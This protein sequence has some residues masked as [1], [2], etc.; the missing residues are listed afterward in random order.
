MSTT[1][2]WRAAA[3][4]L[5][6]AVAAHG[7]TYHVNNKAG[8]DA[9]DGRTAQAAFATIAKAT[10]TARTSDSIVLAN[11]G[12]PYR[13]PIVLRGLGGTVRKPFV[14]EGNGAVITGLKAIAAKDWQ[15]TPKGTLFFAV[16]RKPYGFP[17]LVHEGARLPAARNAESI[18]PGQF[19]WGDKGI[20]FRPAAG[21]RLA[22]YA[23]EATL[24]VSGLE[25]SGA[26]YVTCRNLASEYHS[27]DGFNVHGDC[28]GIVCENIVGRHNGDD[29]FSVHET[30]G[31]VVRNGHFHHNRWGIQDV[32]ASR[33]VFNGVT[34]EHNE[35]NGADF[36]G[37]YHSLVDCVVRDNGRAQIN[38]HGAAPKH[39][40][41]SERNPLCK[42]ILYLSNVVATG[43]SAGLAVSGGASAVAE[44]C[45]FAGSEAGVQVRKDSTL[46]L[47]TSIVAATKLEL[48][49]MGG[50]CFRD[51]NLYHP[52]RF[53]WM[54]K[55][56]PPAQWDA[57][58]AAAS[59][60][61]H[62]LLADPKLD[63]GF[64]PAAGSP[65]AKHRPRIGPS[66]PQ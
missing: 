16:T 11:T 30:I 14:I 66:A 37:G 57:F 1:G 44:H 35:I 38:V 19:F 46:H 31:A 29:G 10:A 33:S 55:V 59:H 20:H 42:G 3:V 54:G 7:A 18:E 27:N 50:T 5:A 8:D 60:D 63:A 58:R 32:N 13:E 15:P 61:E 56:Y 48:D 45:V 39:L 25:V 23:L 65:A 62:S 4:L 28:R 34:C 51:H 52:G 21:K 36:V 6:V 22:D 12:V 17:F 2:V 43:G 41:G 53:R 24:V 40:I 47:T 26:S 64:H 49:V 9:H